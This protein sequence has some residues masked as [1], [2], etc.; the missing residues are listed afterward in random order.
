METEVSAWPLFRSDGE[1][2]VVPVVV[3]DD[4]V[5]AVLVAALLPFSVWTIPWAQL[6]LLLRACGGRPGDR[7]R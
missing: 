4:E 6:A 3:G 1:E 7:A 2:T 5:D